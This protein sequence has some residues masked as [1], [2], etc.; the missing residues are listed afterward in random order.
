M[1]SI[2][3][4]FGIV[5]LNTEIKWKLLV[6]NQQVIEEVE[7]MVGFVLEKEIIKYIEKDNQSF[8]YDVL[9]QIVNK[10]NFSH[11]TIMVFGDQWIQLG[12]LKT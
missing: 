5:N 3:S 11:T 4:R 1:E 12:T 6:K 9:P 10:I 8:E 2:W 7:L